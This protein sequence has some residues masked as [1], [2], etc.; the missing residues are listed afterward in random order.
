MSK[1]IENAKTIDQETVAAIAATLKENFEKHPNATIRK[2]AHALEMNYMGLLNAS[3]KPVVGEAYDLEA[4]NYNAMAELIAK[5]GVDVA[6]VNWEELETI[7]RA[8]TATLI[9][10]M[11]KFT[12]GSKVYIRR[13]P[14]TPY[15]IV[16]KT[17]TH[18]VLLLEGSTEPIAWKHST[19][20]FNGPQFEPRKAAEVEEVAE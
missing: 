12:V 2:F 9:K 13:N 11:D 18:I 6:G 16:Y 14:T 8:S 3:R 20:L 17:E 15:E 10:D 19:F 5:N 7:N 1:K 4:K